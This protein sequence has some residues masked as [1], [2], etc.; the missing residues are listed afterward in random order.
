VLVVCGL[1]ST[2]HADYSK[3]WNAAKANLP[4]NTRA[5]A[6]LD[7]SAFDRSPHFE[8]LLKTALANE[9]DLR[10]F[11]AEVKKLCKLDIAKV[12]EGLVVAGDPEK[13]QIVFYVQLAADRA[14]VSTCFEAMVNKKAGEKVALKQEGIYTVLTSKAGGRELYVAWPAPNV[15]VFRVRSVEQAHLARWVGQTGW[16]SSPVAPLLAKTD[17]KAIAAGA[18]AFDKPIDGKVPLTSGYGHLLKAGSTVTATLVAR[19]LDATGA[20]WI[21]AEVNKELKSEKTRKRVHEAIRNLMSKISI[22]AQ[23]TE[24]TLKGTGSEKDLADAIASE[25]KPKKPPVEATPPTPSP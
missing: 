20:T 4:A 7:L 23:G 3:A 21:A 10:E 9:R 15:L 6:L 25:F 8:R 16:T 14:K 2:A 1:A 11:D 18:F 24:V 12:V 5:V 17:P 22:T 19:A 13:P